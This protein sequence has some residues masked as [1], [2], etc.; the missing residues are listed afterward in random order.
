[1][2][3]DVGTARQEITVAGD[4]AVVDLLSSDQ[5]QTISSREVNELPVA[6]LDWTNLLKLGTGVQKAGNGGVSLNGLPPAGFSLTV[7]GTNASLDAELPSLA[8]YQGFNVINTIN[9]DAIQ[10]IST[11]KGIAPASVAGS[12]GGNVNIISKGGT[13][14]FHGTLFEVNS[15]AAY[16]ARNQFL[17]TKP[18]STLNQFGGSL[19]GAV[20]RDKLFYFVNFEGV[21]GRAFTAVSD[22]VPTPGFIAQT[23]AVAP[24]YKSIFNVYPCPTNRTPPARSHAGTLEPGR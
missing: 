4:S 5:H 16:N 7:D 18:G 24:V 17:A 1:M 23:L 14:Q 21:R 10:E 15:V 2:Q 12:M 9:P 20:I 6:K 3:L 13:N 11:T 19:G 22:D 8:F